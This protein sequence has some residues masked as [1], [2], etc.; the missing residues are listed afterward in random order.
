MIRL[1]LGLVVVL[2]TVSAWD[3][4]K[5]LRGLLSILA[6]VLL[7][8]LLPPVEFITSARSDTNYQQQFW[9]FLVSCLMMGTLWWLLRRY[10]RLAKPVAI[11]ISLLAAIAACIGLA[12][13][14]A[15]FQQVEITVTLGIGAVVFLLASLLLAGETGYQVWQ[16]KTKPE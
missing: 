9:V 15:F 7:F 14:F 10:T 4:P 12:Q 6:M 5:M 2:L 3:F 1:A 13:G 8:Q 16:E 11:L